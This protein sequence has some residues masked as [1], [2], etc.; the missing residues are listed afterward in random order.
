MKETRANKAMQPEA[1]QVLQY[2]GAGAPTEGK[3]A[4]EKTY[5]GDFKDIF[6]FW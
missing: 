6:C 1:R 3:K 4:R 5:K 2:A